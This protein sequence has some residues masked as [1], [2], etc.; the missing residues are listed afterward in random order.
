MSAAAVLQHLRRRFGLSAGDPDLLRAY[1]ANRD[2]EA[3]RALVER[4]GPLV[5]AVCRRRRGRA[6][7][8]SGRRDAFASGSA[9]PTTRAS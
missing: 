3:F 8:G 7:S 6:K 4:P 9:G 1:A 5:F 2:A